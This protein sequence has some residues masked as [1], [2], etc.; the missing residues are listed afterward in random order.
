MPWNASAYGQGTTPA[1]VN[2]GNW[3]AA[4]YGSPTEPETT[5]DAEGPSAG[6][7]LAGALG[8]GGA[9]LVARNPKLAIPAV[10]KGLEYANAARQ[11]MM[12]SGFAPIKSILGNLG[13]AGAAS[14]E[15]RSLKP[16]KELLS[17][18]TV[19]DAKAAYKAGAN[20]TPNAAGVSLPGPTPG[21]I[22]GAFDDAT[23]K[24]LQRSGL[25]PKESARATF[26]S[27]L[28]ENYGPFAKVL[29]SPAA[30][31]LVPFRR[32]PFNQ[33]AEGWKTMQKETRDLP[34]LAGY[35]AAGAAH[36]ALTEDEKYPVSVPFGIAAA[37][38]YGLPYGLAAIAGR[39]LAGGKDAGTSAG[40]ILPVSEYG[41]TQ[42]IEEPLAPFTDPSFLRAL[43]KLKKGL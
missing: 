1:P 38:K 30:D 28:G 31:Y 7:L 39:I 14:A 19:R 10:R 2:A 5:P 43:E 9:A 15:R 41:I 37:A 20:V 34:V 22:M 17:M 8:L 21:R 3:N 35:G 13:A 6:G 42:S 25:S 36:G 11:Q 32:T 12:L 23:Q 33:F 18:Q 29:D 40:S 26:Q 27:P 24:A 4:A 16:L